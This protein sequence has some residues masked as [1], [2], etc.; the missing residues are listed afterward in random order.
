MLRS[1]IFTRAIK[2]PRLILANLH[3]TE[4]EGSPNNFYSRR[5]VK[6]LLIIQR[7]NAYNFWLRESNPM[8]LC[9][10]TGH[11]GNVIT[12]TTLGSHRP[13]KIWEGTKRLKFGVI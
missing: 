9:H 3:P 2:C 8:K 5:G 13:F 1:E 4:D 6:K 10:M 12:Y 11:K 7:I